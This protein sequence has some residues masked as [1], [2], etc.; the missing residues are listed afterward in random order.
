M[1]LTRS[2]PPFSYDVFSILKVYSIFYILYSI[3][4][5][6]PSSPMNCDLRD[7]LDEQ[8]TKLTMII[9]YIRNGDMAAKCPPSFVSPGTGTVRSRAEWA[10]LTSHVRTVYYSLLNR[11]PSRRPAV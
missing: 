6:L 7:R 4:S 3:L 2:P 11:S 5:I 10:S 9:E 8:Y 1:F